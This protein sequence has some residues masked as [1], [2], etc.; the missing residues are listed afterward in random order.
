MALTITGFGGLALLAGILLIGQ[1]LGSFELDVVLS[2]ADVLQQHSL[3]P[4]ILNSGAVGS[5]YEISSIS[6]SFLVTQCD[7][8]TDSGQCLP[9]FGHYGQGWYFFCW[10]G[11]IRY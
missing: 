7:V 5:F 4:V 2:Q 10:R 6:I 9:A 3:Y 8:G 11:C 1:V